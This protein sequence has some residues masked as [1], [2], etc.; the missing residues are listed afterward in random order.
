MSRLAALTGAGGGDGLA[1]AA[2]VA[3][4]TGDS[5]SMLNGE[6]I[7]ETFIDEAGLTEPR[8]ALTGIRL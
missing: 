8:A 1:V 7:I 6:S 5:A 4:G 3:G 2:A